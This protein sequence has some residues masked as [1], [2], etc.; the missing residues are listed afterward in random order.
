[1]RYLTK[2][3]RSCWRGAH[4]KNPRG[5]DFRVFLANQLRKRDGLGS[6]MR[7]AKKR[8]KAEIRAENVLNRRIARMGATV[9]E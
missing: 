6:G 8:L 3:E 9:Y 5:T 1:M 2:M 7:K 4:R